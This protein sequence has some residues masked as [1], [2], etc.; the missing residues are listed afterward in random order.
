MVGAGFESRFNYD[1]S[2]ADRDYYR[3][4]GNVD[5]INLFFRDNFISVIADYYIVPSYENNEDA[6]KFLIGGRMTQGV[7]DSVN[8]WLGVNVADYRY[9]SNPI[10]INPAF[11]DNLIDYEYSEKTEST[12][13][14]YIGAD[15]SVYDWLMLQADYTYS[16]T[17]I[18][19][20]YDSDFDSCHT[21][22]LWANLVW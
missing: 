8:M 5:F 22:A 12:T 19:N 2:Y 21:V 17:N 4:Y 10:Y 13:D 9:K 3:I 14:A 16:V 11:S 1:E 18:F 15:W 20:T 7:T 6:S